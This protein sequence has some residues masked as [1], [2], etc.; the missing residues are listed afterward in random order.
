MFRAAA[1]IAC[2]LVGTLPPPAAAQQPAPVYTAG[3][4]RGTSQQD[5]GRRLYAHIK[6]APGAKIPF[7]TLSYRVR[8]RQLVAGLQHGARVE[9]RAERHDG[10]NVLVAIRPAQ[11]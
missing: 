3:E 5:G 9:F 7:S 8:D 10:E 1:F 2:A 4:F 6:I 11:R